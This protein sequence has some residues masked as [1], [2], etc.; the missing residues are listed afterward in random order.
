[1]IH[2]LLPLLVACGNQEPAPI[3]VS[4]ESPRLVRRI[5]LDLRGVLPSTE[6]LDN[7]QDDESVSQIRDRYLEDSRLEDS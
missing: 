2:A 4:L 1:M 3:H 6:D 5:S 7:A